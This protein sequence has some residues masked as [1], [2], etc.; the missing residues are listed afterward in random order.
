MES[1]SSFFENILSVEATEPSKPV[2]TEVNVTSTSTTTTNS[3]SNFSIKRDSSSSVN[4]TSHKRR[5]EGDFTAFWKYNL[6]GISDDA[7]KKSGSNTTTNTILMDKLVEKV[8][9]M[10]LPLD[11]NDPVTSKVLNSRLAMQKERPPLSI[12]IMSR[13]SRQLAQRMSS[14]FI[15]IDNII[16]FFNWSNKWYTIGVL[17]I[18]THIILN[19]YLLT[20]FPM[21]IIILRTIIP[22]YLMI[23]PPDNS[24]N[25]AFFESNP[26]PSAVPLNDC[27]V[28]KP[29]PEFS[30]EFVMNFTDLQNH[31]MIH[32]ATYDFFVWLTNDYLYFKDENLTSAILIV[33]MGLSAI[34]LI[35]FPKI[36]PFFL[37]N[38]YLIQLLLISLTWGI[39]IAFHPYNRSKIMEWIYREDTRLNALQITNRIETKLL[40]Y[41][42][43]SEN[44]PDIIEEFEYNKEERIKDGSF[45]KVEIFELQKLNKTTKMWKLVG[46]T[47]NIYTINTAT[48]KFNTSLLNVQNKLENKSKDEL[49][50]EIKQSYLRLHKK[51]S[52]DDITPP[53]NW[54]FLDQKWELDLDVKTWVKC[55]L[56][57]DLVSIDDDEKWVYDL[58]VSDS[59]ITEEEILDKGYGLGF[60]E[61]YRRRRWIRYCCRIDNRDKS[62]EK[63]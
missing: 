17:L 63:G 52:I 50:E 24:F 6:L 46:F 45:R 15:F 4:L 10:L 2:A 53:K 26:I 23:Y 25:S 62:E 28:P 32:I 11:V 29:I 42:I 13:N 47:N 8:I 36:I 39:T 1:V 7:N 37:R 9:S 22:H 48:R 56:I 35:I 59:K 43:A 16:S 18:L 44:Q 54:Q 60:K 33:L 58:H 41:I 27:K 3:N 57:E 20:V 34:N 40:S 12:N 19:P 14:T 61:V 21:I 30:R 55:K 38:S 51:I 5:S 49:I 31:Q